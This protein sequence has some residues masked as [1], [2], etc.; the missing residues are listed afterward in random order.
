MRILRRNRFIPL[1]CSALAIGLLTLLPSAEHTPRVSVGASCLLCGGDFAVEDA[2]LNVLLFVPLGLSLCYMG[3]SRR[4]VLLTAFL[5]SSIIELLQLGI[6]GRESS[7]GD[8]ITNTAGACLGILLYSTWRTLLLPTPAQA[9]RC[10][11]GAAVLWTILAAGTMWC[12]EPAPTER[13][14]YGQWSPEDVYPANYRGSVYSAR[15]GGVL[16]PAGRIP[17]PIPLRQQLRANS[18]AIQITTCTGPPTEKLASIVS[19]ADDGHQEILLV[20]QWGTSLVFRTRMRANRLRLRNFGVALSDVLRDS[21]HV[22]DIEA[23]RSSTMFDVRA[24]DDRGTRR[25]VVPITPRLGWTLVAPFP[26]VLGGVWDLVSAGWLVL[27]LIP[28]GYW[29]ARSYATTPR[30][31]VLIALTAIAVPLLIGWVAF[32]GAHPGAWDWCPSAAGALTGWMAAIRI[33]RRE[34]PRIEQSGKPVTS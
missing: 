10:A 31:A 20:G 15:T 14:Y 7:V 23:R 28:S 6:P 11:V 29:A 25:R 17:N 8:V 1:L 27:V 22:V 13:P 19:V 3:Q 26:P 34:P 12:F 18:Q 24:T 5:T 33:P 30:F 21:G 2:L 16:I 32:R 4:L 9:R